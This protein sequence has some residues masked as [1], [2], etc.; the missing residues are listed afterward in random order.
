[1]LVNIEVVVFEFACL[2]R[3]T[4]GN[5]CINLLTQSQLAK[6]MVKLPLEDDIRPYKEAIWKLS[7]KYMLVSF[8]L[9]ETDYCFA[10][11]CSG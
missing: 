1:M 3:S 10:S 11:R 4:G 7:M 5:I 9:N 6:M 8:V 2:L